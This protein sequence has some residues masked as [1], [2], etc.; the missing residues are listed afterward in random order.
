[1]DEVVQHLYTDGGNGLCSSDGLAV[2]LCVAVM[3][4]LL[5]VLSV[6]VMGGS[7][8]VCGSNGKQWSCVLQ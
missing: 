6:A 3:G 4:G 7:G 5:V 8:L 2:V 1:M